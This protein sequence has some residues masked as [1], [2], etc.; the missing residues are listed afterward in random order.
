MAGKEETKDPKPEEGVDGKGK[1]DEPEKMKDESE[2]SAAASQSLKDM[3]GEMWGEFCD[4][5]DKQ[6]EVGSIIADNVLRR[7]GVDAPVMLTFVCIITFIHALDYCTLHNLAF[8]LAVPDYFSWYN[9]LAYIRLFSHVF[10]HSNYAHL[11]ANTVTLLLVG[12][13]VER[14]FGSKEICIILCIVALSSAV[15]HTV[16]SRTGAKQ[17]GASALCFCMVLLN[18]LV[19]ASTGTVPLSF[20]I[21]SVLWITDEIVRI[22]FAK[23]GISHHA[24]LV[25]AFCGTAYGYVL[26]RRQVRKR[27]SRIASKWLLTH[28]NKG[29]KE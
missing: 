1:K 14:A 2:S 27:V 5:V 8:I 28:R 11:K 13:N 23:D 9:P 12:P 26:H 7:V 17:M 22:F 21:I 4:W 29:K 19:S 3:S 16:L 6:G 15:I 20:I 10:V 18:S 25:G 24:H